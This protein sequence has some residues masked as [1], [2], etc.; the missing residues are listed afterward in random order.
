MNTTNGQPSQPVFVT[1]MSSNH[2][3]EGLTLIANIRNWW[4]KRKI[5]VY[6]LGLNVTSTERLKGM[7]LL[8]LRRFPFSDYP[9]Y[10]GNLL[11]FRWKPII[12][13]IVLK[14]YGAL[15]YM[16]T[17]V[18]WNND[19][20]WKNEIINRCHSSPSSSINVNYRPDV[21]VKCDKSSLMVH[22][23]TRHGIFPTTHPEAICITRTHL[24]IRK[25]SN[26]TF[27]HI[28]MHKL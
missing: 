27:N 10:V 13:A 7:C 20:L 1:A 14:E 26:T 16:D 15:W 18:R 6:D 25:P 2:Y 17:S 21:L 28:L 11:Q 4:P 3:A 9:Q 22:L 8:E 12:I 19:A 24:Q 5:I 23:R